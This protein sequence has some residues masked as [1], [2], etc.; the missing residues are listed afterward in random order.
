MGKIPM[1]RRLLILMSL[2]V[3]GSSIGFA[4][5]VTLNYNRTNL[6]TVLERVTEQTDYTLAFSKEV[7]NLSDEV[8]IRVTDADLAAVLNQLLT[9]RNIGYEIRDKKIYIFDKAISEIAESTQ[10][11]QQDVNLRGRVTDENGEPVIGV[12]I[13]IPG[14]S[15]GTVTDYDGNYSLSLPRGST[16]RFSYIGFLDKEYTI[17]NQTQLNVQLFEDT[18]VLDELIVV[19]WCTAQER[20]D[21]GY[22]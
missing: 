20:G 16:L 6:R 5:K 15:I 12:N 8:T 19:G 1:K 21:S 13:S 18:E 2:F 9:P 4:Q 11:P 10:R 7:V 22:Q 17:T 14:T 3:L